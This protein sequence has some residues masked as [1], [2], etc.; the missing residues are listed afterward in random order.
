MYSD[1]PEPSLLDPNEFLAPR[2]SFAMPL[3]DFISHL[4][5]VLDQFGMSVHARSEFIRLVSAADALPGG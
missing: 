2:N 4:M 1:R 3:L 5:R